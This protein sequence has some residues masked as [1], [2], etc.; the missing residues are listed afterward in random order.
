VSSSSSSSSRDA[1][2]TKPP[3]ALKLRFCPVCG[4]DDRYQPFTGKSHFSRGER[5]EGH[6]IIVHYEPVVDPAQGEAASTIT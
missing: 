3:V 6:P 4:Q 5:C 1:V 2:V